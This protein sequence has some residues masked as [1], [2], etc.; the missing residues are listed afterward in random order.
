MMK[1]HC[2][3][4]F[5][6]FFPVALHG[7]PV[8]LQ[9]AVRSS[10]VKGGLV[11]Q[12]GAKDPVVTA[13]LR[14]DERYMVQGLS[15]DASDVQMARSSLHSRGLYGPVSVEQFDGKKLPYIENFVN[16]IVADEGLDVSEEEIL[17]VLVPEGVA[18]VRRNDTWKKVVKPRPE[19]IDDWTHYFHNPSGN[20][21]ARDKV[22][23]PPRRMQWAGSPRWSR[24]HDR[25]AS[26]SALVSGGGR[27]FYIMDE[28]SRVSI[29]LPS[30]WQLVARDAFN[31]A[32]LWKKPITKWHSQLWP[33]KSGPSQ[34]ARR[35]VVDGERL[36]VTRS[37]SGPV[38]HI[39]AA[40]GVTRSVFEG[41]EKT[42]EIV[43]HDGLLFALVREGKSELEDYVPKNNV[44]DQARVRTEFV[45]NARPRSI[46]VYDSGS[47]KFLWEKE[48]K[49]SPLSLSVA[50]DVL[51]YHDGEN[52]ACLDC[53][54]GKQRWRSEK[55]GRRT[56]IPF[57]FAPRLVIYE[58]VVLYAGGDNKM[59]GYDLATGERLWE[60]THDPSG[61]QSPQDLLVVAGLVWSAP[62]T[63]GGHSGVYTGRDPRT[64]EVKKQ[65]PPNVKTYWFH[66]RCYIAKAT[67]RFLIPSRTGIEFVDFD[68]EHW[69]INHWVRGGCLYG[70]MPA[71]GLTYAPPHNCA[72]YPE[73]KLYGFNALAPA[74]TTFQ[75]PEEISDEGRLFKGAAFTQPLDEI[76]AGEG[77][78]P[79]F[80][81][82]VQ[83]SGS[84]GKALAGNLDESWNVELGGRLSALTIVKDQVYVAQVDQHTLHS[85]SSSSGE[86][87]WKF[88]AGA[89][90]DSPPTYWK[91]RLVFGSADGS[92]YC[93]RA[94]DGALIWRFRAAPVDRRLMAFEQIESVWP[95]HG[96]ILVEDGVASFVAGRSTFLDHG[97]RYIQLDVKTG[98]KLMERVMDHRDPE[99]GD[100][101]QDRLQTLQMQV[102]LPDIL[103]SDGKHT[104]LRSQKIDKKT[105]ER[106]EVGPISG[107]AP[108]QGAAQKGEGAHLFAPMGF[109]DDTYFHRAYWVFGKNFA[110]GHNGYYQAGKY[111]P[112]GRMLVF[113][114]D[115]VYG[116]GR[117]PKYLRWTTTIEHQLFGAPREA[118]DAP[119]PSAGRRRAPSKALV[120][121]QPRKTMDPTG[122][123]VSVECWVF[124][125]GPAGV[126]LAHGGPHN[127]YALTLQKRIPSFQVR[128][129]EQ[130]AVISAKR[131][132][133]KGWSHLVGVL[134]KD[135]SMK[136]YLNG[137]LAAEGKAT[138]LL[139]KYPVQGLDLA[140]DSGSSVG[141][142]RIDHTFTGLLDELRVSFRE[143]EAQEISANYADPLKAREGNRNAVLACS[144]DTPSAKDESPAKNNGVLS[145]VEVGKG[146][147][148]KAIWFRKRKKNPG[149]SQ[150]GVGSYV[151][152]DWDRQVPLFAQGMVLAGDTLLV[153]GPPDIM[154]EEYTFERI[155]AEDKEVDQVL[156][157]QDQ[158]L[159]GADGGKLLSVSVSSGEQ[160]EELK[161]DALPVW[162]GMAVAD[163][164]L[165]VA[166]K[167]GKVHRFGRK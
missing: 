47:G 26:M 119:Q 38:E 37:I 64:G 55:A 28:G 27:I 146:R 89:R 72:C 57:N 125:D 2:L 105:G 114:K 76:V 101:I 96:T 29:Q 97:L 111:A 120:S 58:D 138:G 10:G 77:D 117:D 45:W 56:L 130:L 62:L 3:P 165:F 90:I 68:K 1:I 19:E 67:E 44:G 123:P 159:K 109:L 42:E 133:K 155:V 20:A 103:S 6:I 142:Y 128:A 69:D 151:Q 156:R 139:T 15:V 104:Y 48:D 78:W 162:D 36:F 129:D 30:D 12:L 116:F 4:F 75:L 41:S 144:F 136:L 132:L 79:T 88:T 53:R 82:N 60:A 108:S 13:S 16:L 49:I 152:R 5:L 99:T 145:G 107:N 110:G 157:R 43:H 18:L 11:V 147:Q 149:G 163:G 166:T 126:I 112:A 33:L 98:K 121:F 153:A 7:V 134:G 23:G 61:Y 95:V 34:L 141:E 73:A 84:T 66:H 80:R 85:L 8:S 91:G 137:E 87:Q 115:K 14:L 74:S 86:K 100:D 106:L 160:N 63:S 51:V 59:Q 54:T 83:R 22:V 70:V 46:R 118:P 102:G 24:H 167:E 143:V 25:M 92:V 65:F 140:M 131:P 71:N 40:T 52:V 81:G 17:R 150:K 31:G 94:K 32:I 158:V 135:K 161:L 154:D 21:V 122:K 35:L 93:L 164:S 148:G 9:D 50:G 39:D 124:P 113:N 127:G